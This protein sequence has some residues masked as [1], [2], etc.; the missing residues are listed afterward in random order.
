ML[1]TCLRRKQIGQIDT[2]TFCSFFIAKSESFTLMIS[3]SII[4]KDYMENKG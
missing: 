3:E 2:V 1:E 4:Q